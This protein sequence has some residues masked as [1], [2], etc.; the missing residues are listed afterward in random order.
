ML[1]DANG[2]GKS[3]FVSFFKMLNEM[4]AGRLQL[5]IGKSGGAHSIL[6]FGPKMTPQME[7]TLE[8][9]EPNGIDT[10]SV[11]LSHT[12]GDTLVFAE[13][14]LSF[15]RPV[16]TDPRHVARGLAIRKR[17]SVGIPTKT[18][19]LQKSGGGCRTVVGRTISMIPPHLRQCIST[20]I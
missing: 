13:E 9:D 4:M 15:F 19:S 20:R 7:A 18:R 12:A 3:N 1:I 14:S 2:S 11:T 10:Y 5:C 16:M 17:T 6:H 8:F